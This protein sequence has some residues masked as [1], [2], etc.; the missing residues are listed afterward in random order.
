M[1]WYVLQRQL[2]SSIKQFPRVN[3]LSFQDAGHSASEAGTL[4][5][6]LDAT[7]EFKRIST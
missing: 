3:L 6:L 2:M 5:S 4:S 7:D 1:T